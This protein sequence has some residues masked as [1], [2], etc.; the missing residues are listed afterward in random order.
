MIQ[1]HLREGDDLTFEKKNYYWARLYETSYTNI[2]M[3]FNDIL[4]RQFLEFRPRFFYI[5]LCIEK[6]CNFLRV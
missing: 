5:N 3:N 2:K 4:F 6:N 1:K